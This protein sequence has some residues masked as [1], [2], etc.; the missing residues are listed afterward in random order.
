MNI[1]HTLS[2]LRFGG[3]EQFAVRV[4][5][6]Q[7][8]RGHK[9]AI[10]A[11]QDGP[12]SETAR[13]F[14]IEVLIPRTIPTLPG[15]MRSVPRFLDGVSRVMSW[16]PDIIHAHNP[17]SL[18]YATVAKLLTRAKLVLTDH[19]QC[20]GVERAP[21]P[22]ELR[23]LDALIS[24]S[25]DVAERHRT[26]YTLKARRLVIHNGVDFP[27]PQRGKEKMRSELG[28]DNTVTGIVV[29]RV[30]PVKDHDTLLEAL[31]ILQQQ[32]IAVNLI[33]AGD[34][35]ERA[36]L[37]RRLPELGLSPE[38]I[39]FVGFRKDV[40]DLLSAADFFV[41]SSLQE[42]LP[43]AVLEALAQKLPVIATAVGGV[44]ELLRDGEHGFMIP[45]RQPEVLAD[46]ISKLVKNPAARRQMGESGASHV[47]EHFHFDQ[48]VVRYEDVYR[49]LTAAQGL[50]T[51][52]NYRCVPHS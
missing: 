1:V 30:D 31:S 19:G 2:S 44:P 21:K 45:T 24:V 38:R 20:A 28:L 50:A 7:R 11:L 37:E 5:A 29:A 26:L 17:T 49:E 52:G 43:L 51:A 15:R 42:G 25:G 9:V 32:G 41:L 47:R 3:M 36:R 12:L 10:L 34:G 16:K 18:H 39:R 22:W 14:N 8:T 27:T 40:P 48:M 6:A 35:S 33:V 46:A 4:A 23:H 13:R